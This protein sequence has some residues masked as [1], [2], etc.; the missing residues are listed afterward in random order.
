MGKYQ[1]EWAR[2][3]RSLLLEVLGGKCAYEHRGDCDGP[4]TVDCIKPCGDKHHKMDTSARQSFYHAQL[5]ENN[6]QL[7]CKKHQAL[8][9]L[10]D[11]KQ[12]LLLSK[13]VYFNEDDVYDRLDDGGL[14][15]KPPTENEPF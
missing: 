8:K 11:R 10:E 14:E 7:L 12:Q 3:R 1:K 9:S 5:R 15:P 13:V 4:I 2:R 6:L